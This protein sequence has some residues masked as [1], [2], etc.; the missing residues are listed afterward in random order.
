MPIFDMSNCCTTSNEP[1]VL[2]PLY[3]TRDIVAE[4]N[5]G[6]N[7]N[8]GEWSFG[9]GAVGY[10]GVPVGEGWE[11]VEMG[12]HADTFP[13]LGEVTVA[14]HNHGTIAS[15]AVGNDIASITIN[16]ST[17]QGQVNNAFRLLEFPTPIPVPS[18]ALLGFITRNL[19]GNI[20]DCRVTARLRRKVGDYATVANPLQSKAIAYYSHA[21]TWHHDA[22][23]PFDI[24]CELDL[25]TERLGDGGWAG[26]NYAH[27]YFGASGNAVVNVV[28][29]N[30]SD[31][32]V[33]LHIQEIVSSQFNLDFSN[34]LNNVPE[35]GNGLL[36]AKTNGTVK[37]PITPVAG[38]GVEDAS[39][40][41][42]YTLVN[43]SDIRILGVNI[44][45]I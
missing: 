5:S 38:N 41:Y 25:S 11:V 13:A 18:N 32:D 28:Y 21:V 30:N 10:I 9:N 3:E 27:P 1:T 40:F 37:I 7:N 15:N 17:N 22:G 39:I 12:F 34:P 35:I 36:L 19:S 31:T 33:I 20:S 42:Y 6:L 23:T 16:A 8:S 4:E 24:P 29:S 26:D 45:P 2:S 43:S 14:L 44:T